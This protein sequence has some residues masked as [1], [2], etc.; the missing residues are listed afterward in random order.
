VALVVED[1]PSQ[2]QP[3]IDLL[4][5]SSY[6]VV[7]ARDSRTALRLLEASEN[8][9]AL[10]I[11]DL[12]LGFSPHDSSEPILRELYRTHPDCRV[13]VWSANLGQ[14]RGQVRA[15]RRITAAN[16][17][18][19]PVAKSEGLEFLLATVRQIMGFR[20]GDLEL[21]GALVVHTHR[22]TGVRSEIVNGVAIKLMNAAQRGAPCHFTNKSTQTRA[23]RRL[24][25]QLALLGSTVTIQALREWRYRL[26][27]IDDRELAR[28]RAEAEKRMARER[29][30]E[31][32]RRKR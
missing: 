7:A 17:F 29:D 32:N 23:L 18:M 31:E 8:A 22:E 30:Y 1:D 21:K 3:V 12:E 6:Q 16:P 26:I 14:V 24:R 20:V 19:T 5:E 27:E 4:K 15:L 10:A 25:D 11:L 9:P 13:I 2:A 28:L